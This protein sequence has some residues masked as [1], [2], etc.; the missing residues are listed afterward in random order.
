MHSQKIFKAF[1]NS[2]RQTALQ[3]VTAAKSGHPGGSFSSIDFL[4]V[5]YLEK[6]SKNNAPI[7]V[8]NDTSHQP[9]MQF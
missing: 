5:L 3:M 7:I 2:V 9:Y 1:T 6:I 4:S 8:S